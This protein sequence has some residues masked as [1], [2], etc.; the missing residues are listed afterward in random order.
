MATI[1]DVEI[2]QTSRGGTMNDLSGVTFFEMQTLGVC[3]FWKDEHADHE[4]RKDEVND[5]GKQKTKDG[6]EQNRLEGRKWI[7]R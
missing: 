4:K 6:V 3:N 5:E 2:V 1:N 7:G